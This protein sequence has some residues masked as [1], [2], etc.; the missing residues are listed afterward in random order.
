M[1]LINTNLLSGFI[2]RITRIPVLFLSF[3]VLLMSTSCKNDDGPDNPGNSELPEEYYAGGKLG[4]TTIN[5]IS[6][7]YEQ[8]TPAVE[9]NGMTLAFKIG[10][11][12]FEKGFNTNPS[13]VRH[14]LGPVY[15]RSSCITCHPGYGHGKRVDQYRANEF[16]N[17]YLLVVFDQDTHAFV[18][19]LT[20]MPQTKAVDPFL[21]PVDEKGI[22]IE[23]REHV[24]QFGNK[25]LTVK[26]IALFIRR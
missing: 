6:T 22:R 4:T 23:W 10:E 13:G 7:A 2:R 8:P 17:G 25:F 24:D 18:P 20:G 11:A 3:L 14:G 26:P 21:P 1:C 5:N 12:F 9:Q 15:V 19:E 16:G